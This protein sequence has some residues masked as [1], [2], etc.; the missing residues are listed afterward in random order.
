MGFGAA[1]LL[2]GFLAVDVLQLAEPPLGFL[3]RLLVDDPQLRTLA[4]DLLVERDWH[5]LGFALG[6]AKRHGRS[7]GPRADVLRVGQHPADL[8]VV[9]AGRGRLV[10]LVDS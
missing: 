4:D 7:P 5:L 3:P 1:G 2:M 10:T 6:V 9:P 8:L